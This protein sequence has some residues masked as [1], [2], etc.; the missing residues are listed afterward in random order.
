MEPA[1]A[2]KLIVVL[3]VKR[4]CYVSASIDGERT[5]ERLLQPGERQ[6]I[7][8][9]REMVITAGDA[10]AITLTLNGAEAKPLGRTGE[11]VTARFNLTNYKDYVR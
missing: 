11:V 3:S 1:A 4:P 8:V 7:E 6:T 9:Q 10:S 5:I 2:E